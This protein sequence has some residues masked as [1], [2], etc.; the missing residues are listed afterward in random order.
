MKQ[1]IAATA[2]K[3]IGS[4]YRHSCVCLYKAAQM[5]KLPRERCDEIVAEYSEF[6]NT[7]DPLAGFK[8]NEIGR[9]KEFDLVTPED[10]AIALSYRLEMLYYFWLANQ[11]M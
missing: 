5:E 11:E 2:I 9:H 7:M 6:A 4:N 3:I 10:W 8:H 1:R